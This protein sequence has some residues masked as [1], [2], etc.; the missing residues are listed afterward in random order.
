MVNHSAVSELLK[1][2]EIM[3]R[4]RHPNIVWVY[5]VVLP[6]PSDAQDEDDDDEFG[7]TPLPGEGPFEIGAA[8][9]HVSLCPGTM[10][11]HPISRHCSGQGCQGWHDTTWQPGRP[12]W[13]TGR[14]LQAARVQPS[15]HSKPLLCHRPSS[16]ADRSRGS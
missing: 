13:C 5:G 2:A 14:Q 15:R 6:P 12:G 10:C 11:G 7:D 9:A 4:L 1:E 3:A 16:V 8:C